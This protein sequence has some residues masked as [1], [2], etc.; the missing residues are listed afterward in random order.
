MPTDQPSRITRSEQY[1]AALRAVIAALRAK[2]DGTTS[3]PGAAR[4]ADAPTPP[5]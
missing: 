2:R 5:Q 1:L 4:S 3:T